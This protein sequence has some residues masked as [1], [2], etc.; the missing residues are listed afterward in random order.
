MALVSLCLCDIWIWIL[1]FPRKWIQMIG[2]DNYLM[3]WKQGY[4]MKNTILVMGGGG[5]RWKIDIAPGWKFFPSMHYDFI[6]HALIFSSV[7][8]SESSSVCIFLSVRF[9]PYLSSTSLLGTVS[10]CFS[11]NCLIIFCRL[12]HLG[13]NEVLTNFY[14]AL[15]DIFMF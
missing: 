8:R 7:F 10:P 2:S 12:F 14:Y 5:G 9:Y 3:R 15:V 1:I 13:R 11:E 4:I 6:S